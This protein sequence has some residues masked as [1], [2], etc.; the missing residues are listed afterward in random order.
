MQGPPLVH[1]RDGSDGH[2]L[3]G[4]PA[5]DSA[6]PTAPLDPDRSCADIGAFPFD[7]AYRVDIGR[8]CE[9]KTTF[10]GCVPRANMVGLPLVGQLVAQAGDAVHLPVWFRDTA[11]PDGTGV[12]LSDAIVTTVIP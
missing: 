3:A 6:S 8:Y 2:L 1:D 5:I 11:Q 9:A 4:S 12:G 10:E 7:P